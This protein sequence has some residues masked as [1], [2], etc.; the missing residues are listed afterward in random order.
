MTT[1]YSLYLV[2]HFLMKNSERCIKLILVLPFLMSQTS[3]VGWV[4]LKFTKASLNNVSELF[5]WC[6]NMVELFTGHILEVK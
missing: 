5:L 3:T 1:K 6:Q 2:M 4:A